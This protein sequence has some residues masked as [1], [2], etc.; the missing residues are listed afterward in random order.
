MAKRKRRFKHSFLTRWWRRYEYKHTTLAISLI[1]GFVL[2][3]D[4]ALVQ[5]L[6][7]YVEH[8]GIPGIV[9][10][11]LMFV[12]FFSATPAVILLLAF[13]DNYNPLVIAFWAAI[14][15]AI[16]DWIILKF[17]DERI[18]Y[19]L[20]PIARKFNLMRYI[21]Q[22]RKK[23]ARERSTLIGM[24]MIASPFPDEVGIAML[25]LAHLPTISLLIITFL[26]NAAGILILI[27]AT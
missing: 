7:G 26:L 1:V 3:L 27:L 10:A 11:G 19:E 20:M 13:A 18:A 23:K 24:F 9:L 4:T 16:G 2:L 8:M 21:R 5:A 14:G 15:S 17:F 22:L 12:S 6:L 25:G